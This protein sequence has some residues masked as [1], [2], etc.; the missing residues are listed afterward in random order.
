M[1]VAERGETQ[2]ELEVI[3]QLTFAAFVSDVLVNV[4]E[5]V[6]TLAPFTF[7]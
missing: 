7:H 3:T 6:P 4:D 2:A 5:L 1:L